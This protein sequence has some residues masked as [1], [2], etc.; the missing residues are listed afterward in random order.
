MFDVS[1][2][3]VQD[4]ENLMSASQC[5]LPMYSELGLLGLSH[6]VQDHIRGKQRVGFH[7]DKSPNDGSFAIPKNVSSACTRLAVQKLI[8][9]ALK[10]TV[11]DSWHGFWAALRL[12]VHGFEGIG[13]DH[14]D[15]YALCQ[16]FPRCWE[17]A[18][19]QVA[20]QYLHACSLSNQ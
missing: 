12:R 8:P 20:E 15:G 3:S 13:C 9:M 2:L 5:I 4:Q 17:L 1:A 14:S 16:T 10:K 11:P 7:E 19:Q 6:G 18:L